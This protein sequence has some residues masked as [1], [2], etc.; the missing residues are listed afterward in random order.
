MPVY[1]VRDF[2][3]DS[4]RSARAQ[5]YANLEIIA[6]NDG[7]TDGSL[8][9]LERFASK[10]PELKIY[11]QKNSGVAVAR[12]SGVAL[13]SDA[14]FIMFLDSDDTLPRKAVET[15]VIMATDSHS[16]FVVGR[17]LK[18]KGLRKFE[19]GYLKSAFKVNQRATSINDNPKLLGDLISCN[20]LFR[21]DFLDRMGFEYP[22]DVNYEDMTLMA[23]AYLSANH[24]DIVSQTVY[25]WRR[26]GEGESRSK[27]RSETKS[28][29][30][31]LLSMEQ[32]VNLLKENLLAGKIT[33][34]VLNQYLIRILS[35]DIQL[36]VNYI[37]VAD[38]EF[39]S[40]FQTRA[41]A[42]F[43][44]APAEVWDRAV[45]TKL[46]KVKFALT[47][48]RKETIDFLTTKFSTKK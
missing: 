29:Q 5:S 45:G 24:I 9:I 10:T 46:E 6:I 30:D 25:N 20:K 39:F 28:L 17:T 42:L 38:E 8:S 47:H 48:D 37:P 36:F 32:I 12:N 19:R 27:R 4:I 23:K 14:N 21:R 15:M 11:S 1:N 31:R 44:N 35:M 41:R 43:D 22:V 33:E 26:R 18:F 7:S 16:D 34:E 13:A 3:A 40:E 2:V